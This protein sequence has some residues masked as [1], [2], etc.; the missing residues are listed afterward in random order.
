MSDE[1][2]DEFNVADILTEYRTAYEAGDKAKCQQLREQWKA[3]Q[4][5]DSIHE[6]AFGEP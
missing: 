2:E 5:E 4:G 3:W 6:M 1:A